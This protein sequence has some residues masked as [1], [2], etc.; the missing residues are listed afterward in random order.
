MRREDVTLLVLA[1][2]DGS[3]YSPVQIQKTLFLVTE[4]VPSLISSGD[5]YN[6]MPY[7]YGPFDKAVYD[8]LRQMEISGLV[9]IAPAS[10][11]RWKS[12]RATEHGLKTAEQLKR[13]LDKDTGKYLRALSSWVRSLSF[14]KLVSAIYKEYPEM[15][16]NSIFNK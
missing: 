10:D 4:N 12:Y 13:Q 6:F 16:Q 3:A 5:G 14:S 7:D 9:E 15:K 2:A 8:D 11:A 1:S